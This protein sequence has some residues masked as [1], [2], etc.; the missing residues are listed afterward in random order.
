M[1]SSHTLHPALKT[2]TFLLL[3]VILFLLERP[4]WVELF[5][6]RG[7]DTTGSCWPTVPNRGQDEQSQSDVQDRVGSQRKFSEQNETGCDNPQNER[8]ISVPSSRPKRQHPHCRQE[9]Y[10]RQ[11]KQI[12][13]IGNEEAEANGGKQTSV[14]WPACRTRDFR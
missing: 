7:A 13:R 4:G 3:A 11:G 10:R 8:H 6:C 14:C 5:R 9:E 12:S 2:S 1:V